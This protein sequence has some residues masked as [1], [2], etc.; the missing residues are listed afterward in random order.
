MS[1]APDDSAWVRA[2]ED[3]FVSQAL[4]ITGT[5]AFVL[6]R[7]SWV[8]AHVGRHGRGVFFGCSSLART[9]LC[10]E[11]CKALRSCGRTVPVL[12]G[13]S[14]QSC[15]STL[16]VRILTPG[17]GRAAGCSWLCRGF[18]VGLGS[19]AYT[20]SP[21]CASVKRTCCPSPALE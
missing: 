3:Q 16:C 10:L 2:A 20:P 9:C 7:G 1:Q 4:P 21:H 8:A 6:P 15:F 5:G 19:L 12:A 13:M 11:R 18:S 17:F 14:P